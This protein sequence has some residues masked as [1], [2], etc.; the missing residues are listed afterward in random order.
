MRRAAKAFTRSAIEGLFDAADAPTYPDE[1]KGFLVE[2]MWKSV[3]VHFP[4]I[5]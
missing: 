1:L 2:S 5:A 3:A 4:W